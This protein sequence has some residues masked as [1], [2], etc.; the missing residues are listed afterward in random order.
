MQTARRW[1]CSRRCSPRSPP[2]L[3]LCEASLMPYFTKIGRGRSVGQ[4]RAPSVRRGRYL[5]RGLPVCAGRGAFPTTS[6]DARKTTTDT[7]PYTAASHRLGRT[8]TP[9]EP[10]ARPALRPLGLALLVLSLRPPIPRAD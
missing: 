7:P 6:R 2:R 4:L 10:H 8:R 1:S 5:T 3:F 9:R